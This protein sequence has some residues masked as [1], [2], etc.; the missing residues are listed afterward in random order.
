MNSQK[1]AKWTEWIDGS[2][3]CI[4]LKQT[5][6]DLCHSKQIFLETREIVSLNKEINQS[7]A[8]YSLIYRSYCDYL[9]MGIRRIY[10]PHRDAI[11]LKGLLKDFHRNNELLSREY[12]LSL[13]TG[14]EENI[15]TISANQIFGENKFIYKAEIRSDFQKI[16]KIKFVI[17]YADDNV[18]HIG[19]RKIKK[20]TLSDLHEALEILEKIVIKYIVILTAKGYNGLTPVIQYN[21]KKVFQKPWINTSNKTNIA[22]K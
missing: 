16:G 12:Y 14:A 4:S 13:D 22:T 2:E 9:I 8:F 18:A 15:K 6:L 3:D 11:S 7:N 20:P 10:K 1:I 5:L 21:W 19:K 17:D